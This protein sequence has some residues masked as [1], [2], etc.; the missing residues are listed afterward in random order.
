[1][2]GELITRDEQ[3]RR[4]RPG[5]PTRRSAVASFSASDIWIGLQLKN[6]VG[7]TVLKAAVKALGDDIRKT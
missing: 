5:R 3:L 4:D 6:L 7:P 2:A 1:M